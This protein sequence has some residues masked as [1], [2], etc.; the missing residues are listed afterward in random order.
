MSIN[1]MKT[2]T[3]NENTNLS[4]TLQCKIKNTTKLSKLIL[5]STK[6]MTIISISNV[7]NY[8]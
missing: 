6:K 2:I 7:L 8:I 5:I 1:G 4:F 3:S